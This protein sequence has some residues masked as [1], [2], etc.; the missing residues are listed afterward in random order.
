MLYRVIIAACPEIHT[1]N[2][3]ILCGRNVEMLNVNV[4]T[5]RNHRAIVIYPQSVQHSKHSVLVI[6][7][8]V[9]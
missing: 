7:K 6:K 1:K 9:S 2:I 5:H 3:N 4:V 8:P